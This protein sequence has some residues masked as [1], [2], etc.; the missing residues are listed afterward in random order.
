MTPPSE[1]GNDDERETNGFKKLT[2]TK[3]RKENLLR[4][5]VKDLSLLLLADQIFSFSLAQLI[6]PPPFFLFPF[7]LFFFLSL[8]LFSTAMISFPPECESMRLDGDGCLARRKKKTK[9]IRADYSSQARRLEH[10]KEKK[11]SVHTC[12]VVEFLCIRF[13][14]SCFFFLSFSDLFFSASRAHNFSRRKRKAASRQASHET[15]DVRGVRVIVN[16]PFP[17]VLC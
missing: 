10:R 3:I 8:F 17:L 2:H 12:D 16:S 4:E 13:V 14:S 15:T 1:R 7:L 5:N 9:T 6:L 11:E